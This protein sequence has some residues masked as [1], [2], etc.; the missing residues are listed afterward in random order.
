MGATKIEWTDAS[1]NPV[2]GCIKLTQGCKLCYAERNAL[3]R[4][5]HNP[6][7]QNGFK[8]TL[9]YDLIDQPRRWRKQRKVFVC[10]MADLFQDA[11]PDDFIRACFDT[12]VACPQH[13]FQ[14]LTKRSERLRQ[15]APSLPWPKNIWAG[16]SVEDERVIHRIA[17][18]A[19]V[20]AHVRFLSLEPLIGPLDNLN[21][22]GIGWV[23]V[24]GESGKGARPMLEDWV[25][26]LRDQ[27]ED[28]GVRLFYKQRREG[29]RMVS[30]PTLDGRQ[31]I[32]WP[33]P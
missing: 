9:H 30:L 8:P 25:R 17:D 12:M 16:V 15:L 31:H 6:R 14:V 20:P 32:A 2:T 28:A 1:W 33:Q 3:T 22:D 29:G 21:L 26:S 18:L 4:L 7:Y 24:G 19:T 11:V 27:C 10:S 5:K 13:V 23:I